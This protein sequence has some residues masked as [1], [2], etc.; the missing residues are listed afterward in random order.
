MMF[1]PDDQITVS[2]YDEYSAGPSIRFICTRCFFTLIN[3][4]QVCIKFH[5]A[6]VSII[7]ARPDEIPDGHAMRDDWVLKT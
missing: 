7:N 4:I 5:R 1:E 2:I 3:M 6:G